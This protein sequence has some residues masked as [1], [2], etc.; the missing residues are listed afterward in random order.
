MIFVG[1]M[2]YLAWT[3]NIQRNTRFTTAATATVAKAAAATATATAAE[4]AAAMAA[5]I[6]FG[7]HCGGRG[8]AVMAYYLY[9]KP[10]NLQN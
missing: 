10:Y 8:K 6:G 2:L 7:N 9:M 5:E 4:E 3:S 1:S